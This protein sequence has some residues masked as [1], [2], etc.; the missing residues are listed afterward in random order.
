MG[1]IYEIFA[2][3]AWTH[4]G[5]PLNRYWCFHGG[6]FGPQSS[7]DRLEKNLETIINRWGIAGE[8][9]WSKL[10]LKNIDCYKELV[11]CLVDSVRNDDIKYRQ[12]FLDRSYVW[13]PRH[14]PI[15]QGEIDVHFKIYYQFIKHSFG[16]KYLEIDP[17][18]EVTKIFVRLDNHSSQK[19]KNN[20]VRFAQDLPRIL[21]RS[22]L[23]VVV[24]FHNSSRIRRLQ[25][26]DLVMGAA[27]S[28][29][30]NMHKKRKPG[31][32]GMTSKQKLRLK[33]CKYVYNNLREIDADF[34]GSKVF[35][36]F[37]TTGLAGDYSNLLNHRLRIWKL[38]PR[39]HVRDVGWQ[40]AHL[41]R[42]GTYQGAIIR[43]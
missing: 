18:G 11:D 31:Q 12:V 8:V 9:K 38:V 22:D 36:W 41:D 43:P 23:S 1:R 32:R 37:E 21:N 10:S 27:G 5:H 34:R 13:Q 26:C 29:G 24:T 39:H 7:L 17:N 15:E 42:Q 28:Y 35:N 4:G 14:N 33:F 2:D 16:L 30:N 6:I 19:H 20:L 3:E 25:I 40:N